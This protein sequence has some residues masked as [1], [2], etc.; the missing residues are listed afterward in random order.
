M[1]PD[2]GAQIAYEAEVMEVYNANSLTKAPNFAAYEVDDDL[3]V[4]DLADFAL[5]NA[6]YV[7]LVE[8]HAAEISARRNAMDNASKNAGEMSKATRTFG[9]QMLI[10]GCSGQ[11]SNAV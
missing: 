2:V 4:K 8:G 1:M 11:A 6:I 10:L 7:A 5:A 3:T 9:R